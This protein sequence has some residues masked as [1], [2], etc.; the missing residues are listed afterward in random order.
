MRFSIIAR[1][2][3]TTCMLPEP[4]ERISLNARCTK[5]SQLGVRKNTRNCPEGAKNFIGPQVPLADHSQHA[6]KLVYGEDGGR[7]IIDRRRQG[8]ERNI[9][10]NTK[11]KCWILLHRA[12]RSA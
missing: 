7:R 9:D 6:M 8:S 12:L 3:R 4:Q 2:R 10:D 1:K 5:S 11:C